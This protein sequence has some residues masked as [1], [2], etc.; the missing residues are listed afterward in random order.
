M[1]SIRIITAAT[2][3]LLANAAH[4]EVFVIDVQL[5]SEASKDAEIVLLESANSIFNSLDGIATR[6]LYQDELWGTFN[7]IKTDTDDGVV[8]SQETID[9]INQMSPKRNG[10]T[11]IVS[12]KSPGT[13]PVKGIGKRLAALRKSASQSNFLGSVSRKQ[14]RDSSLYN[15]LPSL[16]KYNSD[17][18]LESGG[19]LDQRLSGFVTGNGIWSKQ[20][21]TDSEA[22]FDGKTAQ[23]TA[24]ADYRVNN[25][26]FVGTAISLVKGHMVMDQGGTLKNDA[27]TL[28]LYATRSINQSWFADATVNVGKRN[29]EMNRSI[30]F[31]LNSTPQINVN[32]TSTSNP[33]GNYHGFSLGT[34]Y[35]LPT[36]NG[37]SISLL[38]SF[39]Y[40]SSQIDAFQENGNN[41]YN[42]A[43]DKQVIVSKII[44][45]GIEWRQAISMS[46]GVLLPQISFKWSQELEDKS[47]AVNAYFV[48]DPNQ[49]SLSFE[50]GNKD[51]GHMNLLVGATLVLPRG[52][53]AFAQFE[54]QQFVDDYQQTMISIGGRKEF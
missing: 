44:D 9:A 2:F 4:S 12:R 20:S 31:T 11:T 28:L 32:T 40:T 1:K 22:G 41:A 10:G 38:A 24:G 50:T 23:A 8:D 37:H 34:G 46:F 47:D 48:A 35:D 29:F 51:L 7:Y 30:N 27:G 43:V 53:A 49:T 18:A 33:E 13:I 26:T 6:T 3:C 39:N 15:I 5:T 36:K 17:P 52:L 19:L 42:L 21:N 16:I 54:T 45:A 25:K 14:N